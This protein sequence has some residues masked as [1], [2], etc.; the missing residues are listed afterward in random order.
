MKNFLQLAFASKT[1]DT[2][3]YIALGGGVAKGDVWY[4]LTGFVVMC[5]LFAIIDSIRL[6]LHK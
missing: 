3:F 2:A 6:L 4:G 1:T 5:I